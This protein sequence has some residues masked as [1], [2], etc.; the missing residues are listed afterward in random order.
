MISSLT[1]CQEIVKRLFAARDEFV[2]THDYAINVHQ[3]SELRSFLSVLTVLSS[4]LGRRR[5]PTDGL[6][7]HPAIWP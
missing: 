5:L 2:S 1:N 4:S 7:G 6:D 3:Q